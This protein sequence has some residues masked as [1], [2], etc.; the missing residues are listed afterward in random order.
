M[1]LYGLAVLSLDSLCPQFDGCPNTNLF[2]CYFGIEFDCGDHHYVWSISPFKFALCYGFTKNLRYHLSQPDHWFVLDA[3][4][5]ALTSEGIFD[6]INKRLCAICDN[7]TEIF[8]TGNTPPRL[9]MFKL[10][11]MAPSPRAYLIARDGYR[12]RVCDI[13]CNPASLSKDTLKD[14]PFHYHSAL[15]CALIMIEDGLL[16]YH[17]PI[18]GSMFYTKL[19]LV[20]SSLQKILFIAF[21]WNAFGGHFNAFR[22][23][24]HLRLHYYWPGMYSYIKHVCS[25]CPG[26]S[27]LNPTKSRSSELV[28]SFPIE[29]PFMVLHVD[30]YMVGSHTGFKGS[31]MY[32]VVCC[33]MCRFGA[34]EPVSGANA[35][36]FA[37]TIMKIQLCFEFCHTIILDKEK[38]FFGVCHKALDLI[39]INCHVLLGDKHNPML[40]ECLCQY[41]NKGLTI[42][43]NERD[44]VRVTLECRVLLL[45]AWNSCPLPRTDISHSFVVF[46]NKFAFPI[47]FFSGKHW[48]LKSSPAIM[49]SYSKD[50][51]MRLSACCKI[52]YLLVSETG[53]W[54]RAFVNSCRPDPCFNLLGD[55]VFACA[56]NHSDASK[57]Y[58]G[59]LEYKFTGPWQIV[60]S[61]K[62]PL[63]AIEHCPTPTQKEKKH[64]S[65]LT[66]YSSELIPFEPVD[67]ADTQ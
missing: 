45:Y 19:I 34:L 58:V 10:L 64:S 24:H 41:F 20:P 27:L 2:C 26:C 13:V 16:I 59:K 7:N 56:T 32:L 5:P 14:I 63:Y 44:R 35:T 52:P 6:H 25:A 33:S 65:D 50:L 1:C 21:H 3:T 67:G 47:D 62:G 18:A 22:T 36:T 9:C 66:P 11:S 57:G 51:A 29:A 61:L 43:C 40:V 55:N 31:E 15:W 46:G 8:H 39:K 37:S 23:L 54:H 42:M 30:T 12:V 53:D 48:Q 49:E 17:E 38:K 60:E 4:I 28:Y